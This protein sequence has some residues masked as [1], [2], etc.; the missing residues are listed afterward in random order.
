MIEGDGKIVKKK[1]IE[2]RKRKS[3]NSAREEMRNESEAE[4]SQDE[5]LRHRK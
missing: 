4:P 1:I 3:G 5:H 2:C